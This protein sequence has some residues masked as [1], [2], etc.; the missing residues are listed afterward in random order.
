MFGLK[1]NTDG[2]TVALSNEAHSIP[3]NSSGTPTSYAGSGTNISVWLGATALTYGTSGPNTF[4]VSASGSGITPG[5]ASGTGTVRTYANASSMSTNPASITF[6]ITV[7]NGASQVFTLTR[8]Q[9]FSKSI[10]GVAGTN[11]TNG[12]NGVRGAGRWHIPVATLPATS[13]AANT[14]WNGWANTPGSPVLG[15][16]A[17]FYT[18]TAATPTSQKVWISNGGTSWTE[19]TEVVDGNLLVTGTVTAEKVS[20][21]QLSAISANLGT[22]VAG[23]MDLKVTRGNLSLGE[24]STYSSRF[25]SMQKDGDSI[26][27]PLNDWRDL[28]YRT[29]YPAIS[30]LSALLT[31]TSANSYSTAISYSGAGRLLS[32]SETDGLNSGLNPFIELKGNRPE[33][34]MIV[35][36]AGNAIPS[37]IFTGLSFTR[38]SGSRYVKASAAMG[39]LSGY[40]GKRLQGPG[41]PLHYGG[42]NS[43]TIVGVGTGGTISNCRV[44]SGS[45]FIFTPI[46]VLLRD[47]FITSQTYSIT[48]VS[49]GSVGAIYNPQSF[50]MVTTAGSNQAVVISGTPST[51]LLGNNTIISSPA[52][53]ANTYVTAVSG[54]TITLSSNATQTGTFSGVR[55][56]YFSAG[57][58]PSST[59]SGRTLTVHCALYLEAAATSSGTSTYSVTDQESPHA[60]RFERRDS[61]NGVYT[62]VLLGTNDHAVYVAKG[63]VTFD[64]TNLPPSTASGTT[65]VLDSNNSI[66]RL[67]SSERYKKDIEPVSL[68]RSKNI[69]TSAKPVWYRSENANDN[70]NW[71][72]DGLLAEDVALIE[73]RLVTWVYS[74]TKTVLK[75]PATPAEPPVFDSVT[76]EMI[77]PATEAVEAVYE[78]VPDTESPLIPD[79]VNYA[80]FVPHLLNVIQQQQQQ[81]DELIEAVGRLQNEKAAK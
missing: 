80:G 76:G 46:S 39:T 23:Q 34:Q 49:G 7:R 44:V 26:D 17:W 35:I 29:G 16:Q 71:S 78:V 54:N 66:A 37:T 50:T 57:A 8:T 67:T 14:A 5:S 25:I 21:S 2:I 59:G 36:G 62:N 63:L 1:L 72:Y 70:P 20:T 77:H 58:S 52:F 61:S 15:D 3:C 32:I 33:A 28:T 18:G 11:G 41:L 73:P 38:T 27:G 79:A 47:F 60:A 81:I 6:T 9:S 22:V 74:K 69:V 40:A 65:L 51:Y 48:G 56:L 55:C 45:G 12:T 68:V 10:E 75:K 64:P 42:T 19:Q 4:S 53:A 30:S 13:T 43:T 24:D 31:L